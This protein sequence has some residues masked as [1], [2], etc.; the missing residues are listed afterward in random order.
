[1]TPADENRMNVFRGSGTD[2]VIADNEPGTPQTRAPSYQL[3]FQD[4]DF[5]LRDDLRPVRLQLE[6][7]KPQLIMDEQ[8]VVSTAVM[9]GGARIPAPADASMARTPAL[10][11][12]SRYY[13]EAERFARLITHRSLAAGGRE[14]VICTG[15]GPGVM[16]A[17]NKGAIEAGGRS[18]GLGIVLPHEQAPNLFVTPALYS[19]FTILPSARC[20]F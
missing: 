17:G 1:M 20:T 16:E 8:G 11:D 18:I 15:G 7:L 13:T 2:A 5:L 14:W 3:A 19:I 6:L 9:F 12:L 10:A 4:T